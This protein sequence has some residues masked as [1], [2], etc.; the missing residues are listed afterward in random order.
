M[1][2]LGVRSMD[3]KYY[4]KDFEG[5]EFESTSKRKVDVEPD[6]TCTS[7]PRGTHPPDRTSISTAVNAV[8]VVA[9]LGHINHGKTTLLDAFCG[10]NVAENEPGRITQDVRA[11]TGSMGEGIMELDVPS[12]GR[13]PG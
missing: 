1:R 7:P 8:P 9:V 13:Q 2:M 11:M 6:W 12:R 5:R 4:W 10:T 3:K